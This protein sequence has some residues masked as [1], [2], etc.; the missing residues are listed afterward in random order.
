MSHTNSLQS[1]TILIYYNFIYGTYIFPALQ[2]S[3]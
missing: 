2:M 3:E 1:T